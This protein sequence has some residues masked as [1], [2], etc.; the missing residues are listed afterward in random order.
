MEQDE[1]VLAGGNTNQVVRIGDVVHRH[2]MRGSKAIEALLLELKSKGYQYSPRF[3]GRDAS[4]REMHSFIDGEDALT[5]QTFLSTAVL[6][7]SVL[8]LRSF[9]DLSSQF[10]LSAYDWQLSYPDQTR[11]ETVCHNDF[12]PYNLIV[13]NDQLVGII[14]FDLCGPGPR[15]RDVAYLTYW[16]APLSFAANDLVGHTN[17]ELDAGCPRL[18]M[19]CDTYGDI[20][21]QELLEMVAEV[22]SFMGNFEEMRKLL[23]AKTANKL[24][25]EGHLSH[26]RKEAHAFCQNKGRVLAAFK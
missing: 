21:I 12:G 24:D 4:G 9:H 10:P 25:V 1:I 7:Q 5:G 20:D 6:H 17:A 16:M 8:A 11:H 2:P 14:D 22:L 23:G 13:K 26:W 18:H 15:V 3:M 19:I